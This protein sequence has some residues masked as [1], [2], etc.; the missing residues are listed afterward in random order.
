MTVNNQNRAAWIKLFYYLFTFLY[1]AVT[2][3]LIYLRATPIYPILGIISAFFFIT[4]AFS[5]FLNYNFII[6]QESQEKI[7]L[8]YYPLHPLH[9]KF[10]SIEIPKTRLSHFEVKNK[11]FGLRPEI[12]LFQQTDKGLAKYSPVSI[13]SLSKSD[14]KKIIDSLRRNSFNK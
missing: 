7:V 8:R 14:Q 10:K 1:L 6:Y 12:T 5:L 2:I 9:H 13:S 3:L 11:L 4:T